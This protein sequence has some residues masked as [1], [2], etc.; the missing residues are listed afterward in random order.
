MAFINHSAMLFLGGAVILEVMGGL[1]FGLL[2]QTLFHLFPDY[3]RFYFLFFKRINYIFFEN[4]ISPCFQ[5]YLSYSI[6]DRYD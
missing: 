2:N 5:K 3:V 6:V 1:G 4:S